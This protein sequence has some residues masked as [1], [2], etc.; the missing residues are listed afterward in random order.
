MSTVP[1]SGAAAITASV[2]ERRKSKVDSSK[3]AESSESANVHRAK[4]RAHSS[5]ICLR[6]LGKSRLSA[7]PRKFQKFNE[8]PS[9]MAASSFNIFALYATSSIA[10]SLASSMSSPSSKLSALTLATFFL[11]FLSP[12][13]QLARFLNFFCLAVTRFLNSKP[14]AARA[15]SVGSLMFLKNSFH[16]LRVITPSEGSTSMRKKMCPALQPVSFSVSMCRSLTPVP[17]VL[18][19]SLCVRL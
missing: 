4:A 2:L 5:T 11:V 10:R 13:K 12:R 16:F 7:V 15:S 19:V 3:D 18:L 6:R 14:I 1:S 17:Q 9:G 8:P